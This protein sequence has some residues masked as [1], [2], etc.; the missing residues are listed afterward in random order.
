MMDALDYTNANRCA[1]L[2]TYIDEK[3]SLCV[4][5]IIQHNSFKELES[6]WRGLFLLATQLDTSKKVICKLLDISWDELAKDML[7]S[8]EIDQT[9]CFQKIYTNE[10]DHPGGEPFSVILTDYYIGSHS[11]GGIDYTEKNVLEQLGEIA[12]AAFSPII[13]G[14]Q[15]NFFNMN[16]ISDIYNIRNL[17]NAFITKDY[18]P[19]SDL[20][21][22][23]N[24][25][26][27]FLVTPRFRI[28]NEYSQTTANTNFTFTE[29]TDTSD[30]VNILWCNGTFLAGCQL[31]DI[32]LK[33]GWCI[34]LKNN[35]LSW[36]KI[37]PNN[38][39]CSLA[40]NSPITEC[41]ITSTME[42][43]L[44]DLGVMSIFQEKYVNR[45]M[46]LGCKSMLAEKNIPEVQDVESYYLSTLLNYILCVCRF[47]HYIKCIGREKTGSF[48]TP[49]ALEKYL[50][51]WLLQY[52]SANK[53]INQTKTFTPLRSFR[54]KV[55]ELKSNIGGYSC[56][57][58]LEPHV[59]SHEMSLK[60]LLITNI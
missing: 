5:D 24:S 38:L 54:V 57:M 8:I 43:K 49:G 45:F 52:T 32:F 25:R 44:S 15:P 14:I 48:T 42:K 22:N 60:L 39:T 33:N 29:N 50:H 18:L 31:I 59:D 2:I 47:A 36:D 34:N 4:S 19:W 13:L 53:P 41:L 58:Q 6:R 16:H 51:G 55:N 23:E 27:I 9:E 3:I 28:R 11:N 40:I 12:A 56:H 35:S 26:F 30:D 21:A 46:F 1:R 20:R 7:G 10:F 17:D 37:L